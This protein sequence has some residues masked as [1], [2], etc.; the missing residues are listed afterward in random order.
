MADSVLAR[1][2]ELRAQQTGETPEEALENVLRTEAG[3]QLENLRDGPLGGERADQWQEAVV[4]KREQEL[5]RARAEERRRVQLA[6]AW[7]PFLRK[8]LEELE[9]RKNGELAR[10]LG[11]PLPG[12]NPA[13][14]QQL[15]SEDQRQADE[16]LVALMNGGKVSYKHID[17]LSP[18]DMPARSA[19]SRSRTTWLKERR[20]AWLN[21]EQNPSF[22]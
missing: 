8:E 13:I 16:G 15:A 6:A 2:T 5:A 1:Q 3:R 21:H 14:L 11:K 9:L 17:E 20:D 4:R 10:S 22:L 12:E 18:E 7:E 19:A